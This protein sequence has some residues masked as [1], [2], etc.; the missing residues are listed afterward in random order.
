MAAERNISGIGRIG[1]GSWTYPWAVGTVP[2]HP[3]KEPMSPNT[4]VRAAAELRVQVVQIADNLPLDGLTSQEL[5]SLRESA[6]AFGIELQVGTRG[7]GQHHLLN[8]LRIAE[9][10][11]ATLVRSLGGWPGN[12]APLLEIQ[13]NINAVLPAFIDAGAV[14][15]LENYE[16]YPTADLAR[17]VNTVAS[18]SFGICL[19]VTN[20]FG[21]LESAEEI[22][23]NLAPLTINVHLKDFAIERTNYLMGFTCVGRPIGQGQLPLELI[24]SRL[25]KFN[26]RPDLIVEL[27]PPA[28]KTL[29]DTVS[30]EKAW[31]AESV[32]YL[33]TFVDTF[34]ETTAN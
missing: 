29:D 23:D 28:Q 24:L 22:L 20:S 34:H 12:P 19:D 21:A 25:A 27:W 10:L 31:A 30:M 18:P 33:R 2:D 16:V 9:K 14:L 7:I 3:P 15:A 5:Q 26:R 6:Q 11:Q 1:V 13:R 8:Y 32:R 4:L 17:L